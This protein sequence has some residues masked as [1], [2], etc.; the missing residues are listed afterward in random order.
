MKRI[1]FFASMLCLLTAC[2]PT[3]GSY[4]AQIGEERLNLND[5]L[6]QMPMGMHGADSAAFVEE[7]VNGWVNEQLLYRQG[8][9]HVQNLDQLEKQASQYRRDLI[10][11]TYLNERLLA[12]DDLVTDE[13]CQTFY[14]KNKDN[15][16]LEYPIAQGIYIQLL[17]NSSKVNRLKEW[18][19]Q[20]L[21]GNM[22]HAEDLEQY[23]QLRAVAYES[24]SD[25]WVPMNRL[26][27]FM[28][29]APGLPLQPKLYEM[30]D[31]DYIYLLLITGFYSQGEVQPFEFARNDIME[32]L[33]QQERGEHRRQLLEE[34]KTKALESGHLKLKN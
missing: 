9:K 4:L 17:S 22:D 3:D 30:K 12:L 21:D 32:L 11:Q 2:Q 19:T 33:V 1:S 18:L 6:L 8:L 15:L 25:H 27:D 13:E 20:I 29:T 24:Y 23:C 10:S 5:V 7:Y 16:R 34:L 31:K 28:P 26:T 14:D